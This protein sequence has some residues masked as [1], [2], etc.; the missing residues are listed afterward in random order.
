MSN[1]QQS[2]SSTDGVDESGVSSG[3]GVTDTT[4][5]GAGLP[6]DVLD[7]ATGSSGLTGSGGATDESDLGT[8]GSH[9]GDLSGRDL[10]RE[11]LQNDGGATISGTDIGGN[12]A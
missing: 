10:A 9:G 4:D 12:S 8:F 6:E 1:N 11:P 7:A 3:A 5:T 2:Q